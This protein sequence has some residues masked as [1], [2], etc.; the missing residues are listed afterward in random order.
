MPYRRAIDELYTRVES[1]EDARERAGEKGWKSSARVIFRT[2]TEARKGS[3]SLLLP[4]YRVLRRNRGGWKAEEGRLEGRSKEKRQSG[5]FRGCHGS[6]P[7]GVQSPSL[8]AATR[9]R[10]TD[11]IRMP[12]SNLDA[13]ASIRLLCAR[14]PNTRV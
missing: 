11:I 6:Y 10:S 14:F 9:A 2:K 4:L 1:S 7:A 12:R 8:A 13:N 3:V 5:G